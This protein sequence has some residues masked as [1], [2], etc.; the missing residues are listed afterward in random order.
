MIISQKLFCASMLA[1]IATCFANS[2]MATQ[3]VVTGVPVHVYAMSTQTGFL[4]SFDVSGVTSM[5][6]CP[7]DANGFV[8]ATINKP[9]T[10][11]SI[12]PS[13]NRMWALVLAAEQE[14]KPVVVKLDDSVKDVNGQCLA[15]W[16]Y[17]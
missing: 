1:V 16:I 11:G 5:G 4:D 13:G 17:L 6:T 10:I 2:A 12:D 3:Q 15:I 8:E 7:V 14:N 9:G